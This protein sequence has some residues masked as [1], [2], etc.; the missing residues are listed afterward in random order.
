MHACLT[1]SSSLT[2]SAHCTMMLATGACCQVCRCSIGSKRLCR[3]GHPLL[4][5]VV[6]RSCVRSKGS[7]SGSSSGSRE[8]SAELPDIGV[9]EGGSRWSTNGYRHITISLCCCMCARLR[10]CSFISI[11]ILRLCRCH[12]PTTSVYIITARLMSHSH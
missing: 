10:S 12:F 5:S 7:G 8:G 6:A 9:G 2:I 3:L 1:W 4:R 11:S